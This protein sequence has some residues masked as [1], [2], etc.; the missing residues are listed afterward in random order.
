MFAAQHTCAMRIEI[1]LIHAT[2]VPRIAHVADSINNYRK[3][4]CACAC[5]RV[6]NL[7]SKTTVYIPPVAL[8]Y[9]LLYKYD[10][11]PQYRVNK[12]VPTTM[13]RGNKTVYLPKW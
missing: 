7:I 5:L 11:D 3:V 9:V 10:V 13:Y 1:N 2:A 4:L 6:S 8:T 12:V